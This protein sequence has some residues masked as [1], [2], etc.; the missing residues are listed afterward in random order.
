MKDVSNDNYYHIGRVSQLLNDIYDMDVDVRKVREAAIRVLHN[1]NPI[2]AKKFIYRARIKDFKVELPCEADH[3]ISV[4]GR[5]M[6]DS[7]LLPYRSQTM[8]FQYFDYKNTTTVTAVGDPLNPSGFQT[9]RDWTEIG[10]EEIIIMLPDQIEYLGKPF[11]QFIPFSLDR[12]T[13]TFNQNELCVDIIFADTLR[14][15]SGFPYFTEKGIWATVQYM[16]YLDQ[17]KRFYKKEGN[18]NAVAVSKDEYDRAAAQ[19]RAP[20]Q[21]TDNQANVIMKSLLSK[22]RHKYG[23]PYR[24]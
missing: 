17:L 13:M 5:D 12:N 19:A 6:T 11:A 14:D 9:L 15:E 23:N 21:L 24:G 16:V 22:Y 20:E 4:T 1:S 2:R 10:S 8:L 3:I 18:A 7:W